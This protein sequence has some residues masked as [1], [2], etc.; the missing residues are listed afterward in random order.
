MRILQTTRTSALARH[1]QKHAYAALVL[2]GCSEEAGDLGRLRVHAGDVVLHEAFEAHLDRFP[3]SAATVLNISLPA[4]NTF[5]PGLGRMDDP[6]AIVR[7]AE[8]NEA[9]AAV[10]LLSLTEIQ[11]PECRDWPD[12]L[13]AALMQDPALSLSYWSKATGITPWSLSRGFEADEAKPDLEGDGNERA[14]TA[15][16]KQQDLPDFSFG[17]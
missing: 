14:I 16:S 6:D 1:V 3:A 12:D 4:Q 5:Q 7:I 15:D 13:A 8:K 2:S 9:E 17:I 10:L 11:E